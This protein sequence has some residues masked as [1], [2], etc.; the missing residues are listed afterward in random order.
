MLTWKVRLMNSEFRKWLKLRKRAEELK[1]TL[2]TINTHS[3]EGQSL[4]SSIYN[5][6]YCIVEEMKSI[7]YINNNKLPESKQHIKLVK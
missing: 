7:N 2:Q 5:E 4:Y 6:V 3:I 1:D